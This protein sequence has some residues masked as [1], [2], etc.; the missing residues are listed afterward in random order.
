MLIAAGLV[1]LQ[2]LVCGQE[3]PDQPEAVADCGGR[4]RLTHDDHRL[5]GQLLLLQGQEEEEHP[6]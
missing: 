6:K 1:Q 4:V 3:L 5:R 2:L